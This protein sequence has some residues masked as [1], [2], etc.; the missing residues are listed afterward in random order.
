MQNMKIIRDFPKRVIRS[1]RGRILNLKYFLKRFRILLF[2]RKNWNFMAVHNC[3]MAQLPWAIPLICKPLKGK[4]PNNSELLIVSM[5][6]ESSKPIIQKCC[7]YLGIKNYARI[8]SSHVGP[9][10]HNIK[11]LELYRFLTSLD[12][13]PKYILYVD[14]ND[15]IFRE[16]PSL[17]IK[18][19]KEEDA[20]IL[21]SADP[22]PGAYDMMPKA[23]TAVELEAK[24]KNV[25]P[26]FIC[27]GVFIAESGF[28][29][30]I[31]EEGLQYIHAD[32]I[33]ADTYREWFR[34]GTL[35][36]NLAQSGKVFPHGVGCDQEIMRFL[37]FKYPNEMK[38]DFYYRLAM[39]GIG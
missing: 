30:K 31:L 19:L 2:D 27:A 18:L 38:N 13:I 23:R 3:Y 24:K 29:I 16:D 5:D 14:S 28:L 36:K 39:R 4:I 8:K 25:S 32:D 37:Q 34:K 6:N 26:I 10:R 11:I 7:D 17:S 20:K 21:F 1:L 15:V 12:K 9:W 22:Y 35:C 33:S